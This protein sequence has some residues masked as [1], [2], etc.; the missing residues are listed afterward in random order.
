MGADERKNGALFFDALEGELVKAHE[1]GLVD[2]N[3]L[4]AALCSLNR[5]L[6]LTLDE[7]IGVFGVEQIA[8]LIQPTR[9]EDRRDRI[10]RYRSALLTGIASAM[11]LDGRPGEVEIV[12]RAESLVRILIERK[13]L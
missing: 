4:L 5:G 9:G 1:A 10:D 2:E 6:P 11:Y 8:P 13:V 3:A 12:D 7:L